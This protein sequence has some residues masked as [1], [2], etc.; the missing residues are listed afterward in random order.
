MDAC[1]QSGTEPQIRP[2]TSSD[3]QRLA[4]AFGAPPF[5]KPSDLFPRYE[6]DQ[7]EGRRILLVA[8]E[9]ETPA[10]YLNVV[11]VPTHEPFRNAGIPSIE[12]FNVLPTFRRRGIGTRLMDRAEALIA[13]R[14]STVGI[15]VGLYDD[16]GPAIRMYVKRGYVPDGRGVM[17]QD[18]RVQ[19]GE[20]IVL[21]DDAL[22]YLT[23]ELPT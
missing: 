6:R 15:A 2:A 4:R 23:R 22:L 13:E 12:D 14:S 21:D 10:G 9:G 18:R 8:L 20:T 11:W 17:W 16:Y 3:V 1:R 19:G 7:K 5:R